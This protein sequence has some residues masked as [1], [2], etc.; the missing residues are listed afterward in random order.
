M[1]K[2]V[3]LT[4]NRF[5][6]P[7][8]EF[9]FL[10]AQELK[11]RNVEVVEDN[12]CNFFNKRKIYGIAIAFDF[13][14]DKNIGCGLTLNK[15]CSR[16]ARDFAYNL[17]ND[18]DKLT[19]EIF[20]R[21]FNFVDSNNRVWKKYFNKISS[22]T[23]SVFYICTMNNSTDWDIYCNCRDEIVNVFADEIIRCL[24]SNYDIRNYRNR[25]KIANN[26]TN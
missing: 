15:N 24:R 5:C 19:S 20:W 17:S 11:R 3:Y 7:A 23:K 21:D 25:I 8:R 18:I 22:V 16:I 13:Y 2:I 12:S 4:S 10:L 9:R 1:C 14:K 26:K 6:R